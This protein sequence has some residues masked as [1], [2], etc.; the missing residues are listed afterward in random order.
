M[1]NF[2]KK[3]VNKGIDLIDH[4]AEILL[5]GGKVQFID[6]DDQQFAQFISPDP[7]FIP[8]V[9]LFKVIQPDGIFEFP[10]SF[11]DLIDQGRDGS[12]EVNE[13]VWRLDQA[14]HQVKQRFIIVEVAGAHQTHGIAG[15]AQRF[16]HLRRWSGPE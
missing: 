7:G 8:V 10:A 13:Q 6:T 9:E 15:W 12:L 4:K 14:G 11:L 3:S 1:T 2:L 5:V 16:R